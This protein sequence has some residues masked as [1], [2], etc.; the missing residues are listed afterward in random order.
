MIK[1]FTQDKCPN[2]PIVKEMLKGHKVQE[3]DINTVDGKVEAAFHC[4]MSTPT[5]IIVDSDDNEI[6]SWRAMKP[7]MERLIK[8]CA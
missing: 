4:V 8:L 1:L 7:N 6:D 2:C 5:T 3:Y